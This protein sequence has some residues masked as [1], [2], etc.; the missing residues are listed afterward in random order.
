MGTCIT[1]VQPRDGVLHDSQPEG[2]YQVHQI[3]AILVRKWLVIRDD[4]TQ[5][6]H[7]FVVGK[8]KFIREGNHECLRMSHLIPL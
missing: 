2:L 5:S 6:T 7:T 4:D 1:E 3:S 8:N